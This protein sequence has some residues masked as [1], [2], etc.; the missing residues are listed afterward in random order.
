MYVR[1]ARRRGRGRRAEHLRAAAVLRGVPARPRLHGSA[2]HHRADLRH[3]PGRLPDERLSTRWRRR[4]ASRSPA[5]SGDLR[6]LLYCGE[7]IESHALH[8]YLLHA[9]DFLGYDGAIEMARDHRD[10]VER[11]LRL[12]KAGNDA[13]GRVGGRAVHPVNVRVGGFY[14]DADPAASWRRWC[15]SG[16]SG[17]CDA[18]LETVRWWPASTSPTSSS[19]YVFVAAAPAGRLPDRAGPDRTPRASSIAAAE[20]GAAR[21]RRSTSR[22]RTPCTPRLEGAA[23]TSSG[24]L[25]GTAS[26]ATR[27]PLAREARRDAGLGPPAATR[28]GAI[29]V[30]AVELVYALEE[31]LRHHRRRTA[32]EPARVGRRAP[33]SAT[34]PPRHRAVCCT[35][36]TA[37]DEDGT[38]LEATSSRPPRRTSRRSRRTCASFVQA[39]LDLPDAEL[40]LQCERDPQLRPVHLVR[41]PL[42]RLEVERR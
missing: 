1:V 17:R 6:R 10:V 22:T 32:P 28:S 19:H 40:S 18:A 31:A 15:R 33:G 39:R 16:S 29:L 24:R 4:A 13:D 11:A 8:M 14:R 5:R 25:P 30:R 7:W 3:L 37:I 38:I 20:F 21:R 12:K 34:E 9:P 35:T 23:A 27:C 41:H 42:P 26:T 36:A 2:G